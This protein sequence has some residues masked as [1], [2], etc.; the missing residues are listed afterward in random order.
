VIKTCGKCLGFERAWCNVKGKR[1][2]FSRVGCEDWDDGLPRPPISDLARTRPRVKVELSP[3]RI[4]KISRA[5]QA[6]GSI[7]AAARAGEVSWNRAKEIIH[8]YGDVTCGCEVVLMDMVA[9]RWDDGK[10]CE[11]WRQ[12]KALLVDNHHEPQEPGTCI[13][14]TCGRTICSQCQ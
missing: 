1:V 3:T 11:E 8:K 12:K 9:T 14:P 6:T 4:E 7:S 5:Y 13:C 2:S 10:A